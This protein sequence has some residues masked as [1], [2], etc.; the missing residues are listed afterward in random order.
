MKKSQT[1]IID[2]SINKVLWRDFDWKLDKAYDRVLQKL[3]QRAL[4]CYLY[5]ELA[6][7]RRARIPRQLQDS[8]ITLEKKKVSH[9]NT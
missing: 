1:L 9:S 6:A 8:T 3:K 2:H 5:V 4:N 7:I